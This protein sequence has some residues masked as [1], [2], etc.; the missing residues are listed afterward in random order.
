MAPRRWPRRGARRGSLLAMFAGFGFARA[1]STRAA[2]ACRR[3]GAAARRDRTARAR[4]S[5]SLMALT[6]CSTSAS[7]RWS[8]GRRSAPSPTWSR[9][10]SCRSP[11]DATHSGAMLAKCAARCARRA[12]T[13]PAR[14]PTCA[15]PARS[16]APLGVGP[17]FTRWRSRLALAL[18]EAERDEAL[19]LAE[20]GA[21][22]G[23]GASR[24]RR[25]PSGVALRALGLLAGGEEGIDAPARVGRRPAPTPTLAAR[26]GPLADRARRGAAPRQPAAARRASGCARPPT[27]PSAAAPSGSRTRIA[28]GAAGRGRASRAGGP[29]PAPDS[30]TPAERRVARAAAAGA[31]NREIAQ[32]LFVSL[33]TV[34]MHLTNTYRKLGISSRGEL[35]SALSVP[36]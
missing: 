7:T 10:S 17:R 25:G 24:R 15:R 4:T 23:R 33:R 14:S 11:F 29:S 1:R 13:G 27:S 36:A 34:E 22:A 28:R 19:A 35:A 20:R 12:A 18:P 5:S 31:T 3:R 21:R 2:A 16:S 30:L 32:D 26:A 8:N 6:T 9:G